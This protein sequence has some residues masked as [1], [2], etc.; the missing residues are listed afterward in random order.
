M[1]D[2]ET[3][4]IRI[5]RL[6][7]QHSCLGEVYP[8]RLGML[9]QRYL[10]FVVSGLVLDVDHLTIVQLAEQQ[11][12][13]SDVQAKSLTDIIENQTRSLPK[14]STVRQTS[15]QRSAAGSALT[16]GEHRKM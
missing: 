13:T 16:R 10:R 1:Q 2:Q 15:R 8:S 6:Q 9:S 14:W 4:V 12:I 3:L 11:K 7:G 5:A